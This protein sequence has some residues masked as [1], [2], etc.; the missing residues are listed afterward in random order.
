MKL[1][2]LNCWGG[3]I[4]EPLIAFIKKQ[5]SDTDIF[6]FQEMVFGGP[7]SIF[8]PKNIHGQ[9]FENVSSILTDFK[10][11][12]FPSPGRAT[13]GLD[14]YDLAKDATQLGQAIFIRK[15]F[16]VIKSEQQGAF[17]GD[18]NPLDDNTTGHITGYFAYV[19]FE[20]DNKPFTV[21]SIHGIWQGHK[22]D[23][24]ERTNQSKRILELFESKNDPFIIIGDFNLR[25]ENQCVSM[26]SERLRNLV[27]ENNIRTTR[28]KNYE[29]MERY[30]D[31]IA[32][33][34]FT[35]PNIK[36]KDFRVL[37]D[38]VSDHNPLLLEFE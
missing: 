21:T 34:A 1:V 2:S 29:N 6:C 32:D 18:K 38:E 27:A 31:Y 19:D 35:S 33:Y 9:L 30:Q 13:F 14:G 22:D 17:Y 16:S 10:A 4:Y 11:L 8:S 26:L 7:D 3:K 15:S 12:P 5:S 20:K 37:P 24:P 28:N 25:P 23:S 36:V